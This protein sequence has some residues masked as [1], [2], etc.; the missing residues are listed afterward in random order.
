MDGSARHK[1]RYKEKSEEEVEMQER[2]AKGRE[3]L[4]Q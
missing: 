4:R 3:A 2:L 1:A